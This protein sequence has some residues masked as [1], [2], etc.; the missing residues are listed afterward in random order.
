MGIFSFHRPKLSIFGD[1]AEIRREE[2]VP[3]DQFLFFGRVGSYEVRTHVKT[4]Q[5]KETRPRQVNLGSVIAVKKVVDI[6]WGFI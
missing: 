6:N 5:K 4:E 3:T 1:A 2:R